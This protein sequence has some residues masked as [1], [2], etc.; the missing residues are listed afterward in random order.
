MS[1]IDRVSVW[2]CPGCSGAM[3]DVVNGELEFSGLDAFTDG[4]NVVVV[5]PSCAREK[6]W[7]P[8]LS[9]E[10]MIRIIARELDRVRS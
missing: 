10:H 8:Q 7:Y 2:Y 9:I 3:G 5:C 1:K 4:A 6:T